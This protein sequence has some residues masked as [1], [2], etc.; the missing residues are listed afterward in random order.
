MRLTTLSHE[1][2]GCH[3]QRRAVAEGTLRLARLAAEPASRGTLAAIIAMLAMFIA[4][5]AFADGPTYV[6]KAGRIITSS[7]DG[8]W[9]IENGVI[10]VREGTIIAVGR[11]LDVPEHLPVLDLSNSTVMPGLVSASSRAAGEHRGV[12]SIS[13]AFHAADTFNPYEDDRDLLAAGITTMHLNPGWHRLISGRGA[14]V[15]L[16]GASGGRIVNETADITV[17]LN[18]GADNPPAITRELTAPSPD[19]AVVPDV[20]QRPSSRMTRT[21]T[22]EEAIRA[23]ANGEGEYNADLVALRSALDDRT[24]WRV[25]VN[26]DG[27]LAAAIAWLKSQEN[28]GYIVGATDAK[29]IAEALGDAN[30]PI[31]YTLNESVRPGGGAVSAPPATAGRG[32]RGGRGNVQVQQPAAAPAADE[33]APGLEA[34]AKLG[35]RPFALATAQ[36]MPPSDLLLA[37]SLARRAGL[38]NRQ[39]IDAITRIP[40]EILGVGDHVGSIAPGRDADLLVLDGDPLAPTTHIERV[41]V[42]GRQVYSA[43]DAFTQAS[44][45]PI[46]IT[47]GT[48]WMGPND[49]LYNGSILIE[50]GKVSSVGYHVARPPSARVIDAR[51]TFIT[52]GFIDANGHLGL[53]GDRSATPTQLSLARLLGAP[54]EGERLVAASGVTSVMLAPYSFNNA[55]SQV[56]AVKTA[57]GLRDERIVKATAAVAMDLSGS[58]PRSITGAINGRIRA[59][60]E[61]REKWEKYATDLAEWEKKKAEGTLEETEPVVVE[62]TT[63]QTGE[64]RITGTWEVT[65]TG[66]PIPEPVTGKV[67]LRLTGNRFEGRLIEPAPP[68]ELDPRLTGTITGNKVSG[69]IQVET[70]GM[71]EPTFEGE[72]GGE[73]AMTGTIS[74]GE[75]L[76]VNFEARRTDKAAVEF[77]VTTRRR[78]RG[79]GG[80][81]LPPPVDE[82]LEP[83]RSFVQGQIPAVIR[84]NTPQQL[85]EVLDVFEKEQLPFVLI[86]TPS[87]DAHAERVKQ[88]CSGVILPVSPIV[89]RNGEPYFQGA[90]LARKGIAIAVQSDAEENA[91]ALPRTMLYSIHEGLGAEDAIAALTIHPATMFKVDDRIGSIAPGMDAD[92]VI[93]SDH[94]FN[95]ASRVQ[96]VFINGREVKQ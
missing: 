2:P 79:E 41:L 13:A 93:F 48:I 10:L 12:R 94:P 44:T 24:P 72:L 87:V 59:G 85:K 8:P 26:D 64:D 32:R 29:R 23:A 90:D 31:V 75:M 70:G 83:L 17:N 30:I 74:L 40:A 22:L 36:N 11:D 89:Q 42:Q 18:A 86:D 3:G 66:G 96:T 9:V 73:D 14:V 71:G 84:V 6:I 7:A 77:S 16:G 15:H 4:P 34:L 47:G 81:P 50:D 27:D 1:Q 28:R 43:D 82:A 68:A 53:Q 88:L 5:Q 49:W 62:E 33:P 67:A 51:G 54:G 35:D 65:I 63:E 91:R 80:R 45:R 20:L 92:L 37:A 69:T 57:G 76:T 95:A 61:Y 19:N 46:V 52:P 38:S 60:R 78:V 25:Q 21:L 56:S 58:D 39:V 55:G